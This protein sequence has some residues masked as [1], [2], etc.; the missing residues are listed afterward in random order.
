MNTSIDAYSLERLTSSLTEQGLPAFRARQI[1]RWVYER[2]TLSYGEMTDLPLNLRKSL[3]Q[4][5][6]LAPPRIIDRQISRD[7]ARKYV[8]AFSDNAEVETVA[9]PSRTKTAEGTPEHLTVC[10]S[11]QVGCPMACSFCATGTEGLTRS[12]LPGEMVQQLLT[13][14]RD[15]NMRVSHAVAMGQ[16]EPFLNYD[17][18]VAALEIINEPLGIGARHITV[19]TCGILAGIDRFAHLSQQYTL[20]LSLHSAIQKKRNQLMPRCSTVPLPHLKQALKEYTHV[21]GRRP[22]I[23]YLMIGG[24]N[25]GA[26]DLEALSSFCS[27]LFVHINLLPMNNIEESPFRPS[28]QKTMKTWKQTL[29]QR[30]W[31]TTIRSSRGSDID[32]AC[33]QLKNKLQGLKTN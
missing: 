9:I 6:P 20:A 17:N 4:Q 3:A 7:S 23:E 18:L 33:G 14:Q 27:G 28:P 16:G 25:D 26:A 19:S 1:I 30:G 13:V 10:F 21:S 2:G 12:L 5:M 22:S 11:T 24:V 31:E 29:E 32:G 15:M 8:L